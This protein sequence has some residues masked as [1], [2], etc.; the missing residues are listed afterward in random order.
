RAVSA[1]S[2]LAYLTKPKPF[3]L[4]ETLSV[5]TFALQEAVRREQTRS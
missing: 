2:K 5:M 1:S 3:D 4:P